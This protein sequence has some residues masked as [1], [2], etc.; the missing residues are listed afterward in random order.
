VMGPG[1]KNGEEISNDTEMYWFYLQ[2]KELYAFA[3]ECIEMSDIILHAID[4]LKIKEDELTKYQYIIAPNFYKALDSYVSILSL[5]NDGLVEDAKSITRKLL[6]MVVSLKYLSLDVE[7]RQDQYLHFASLSGYRRHKKIKE[8]K[9]TQ[10]KDKIYSAWLSEQIKQFENQILENY[11]EAK[12]YFK[13][14]TE[15]EIKEVFFRGWSGKPFSKMAKECNMSDQIIAYDI[16]CDSSHASINGITN[17][18]NHD[19]KEFGSG[20]SIGDIPLVIIH[21]SK[22]YLYVIELSIDA[23]DLKLK[24][25]FELL[26]NR[27]EEFKDHPAFKD[28][29]NNLWGITFNRNSF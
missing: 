9:N 28:L 1:Y 10:K 22:L 24:D 5:C 17:Y 15:G 2:H 16:L 6:E 19:R 13:S 3:D 23:F 11:E 26:K 7:K 27:L 14:N 4:E 29:G 20:L 25:S 21:A 12:K 8:E 18:C